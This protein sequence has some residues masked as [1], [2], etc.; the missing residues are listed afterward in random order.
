MDQDLEE[1]E[2]AIVEKMSDP[3][4]SLQEFTRLRYK[5]SLLGK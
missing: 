4:I 1:V 2:K 5:L 3:D